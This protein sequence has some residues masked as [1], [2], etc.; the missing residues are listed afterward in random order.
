MIEECPTLIEQVEPC[1]GTDDS[2]NNYSRS[3]GRRIL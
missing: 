1:N 2:Y 3:F